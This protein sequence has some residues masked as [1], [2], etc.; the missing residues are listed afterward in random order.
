MFGGFAIKLLADEGRRRRQLELR[1]PGRLAPP[2]PAPLMPPPLLTGGRR[3]RRRKRRTAGAVVLALV[4][5][6]A[7]L[8]ALGQ[9]EAGPAR[10][11]RRRDRRH[12]DRRLG[13][14]AA[15][16]RRDG[17]DAARGDARRRALRPCRSRSSACRARA[18][19]STST[20]G[21]VL[22]RAHAARVLPIAS[23]TKMMTALVVADAVPP[24]A[25]VR[26][27]TEALAY[28]GSAVGMLRRGQR[29]G[30]DDDALRP[31]AAVGQRRGD[32][33]RPA[34]RAA[35]ATRSWR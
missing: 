9:R 23:L 10:E 3:R 1:P 8:L 28:E 31:A 14:R 15:R 26:I 5:A 7:G 24:G 6:A 35:R 20:P 17:A 22:W 16:G 11:Q 25:K 4:L 2:A 18:C 12:P 33:A 27:T 19:C 30:V 21:R 13:A 29:F 32:R 34:R